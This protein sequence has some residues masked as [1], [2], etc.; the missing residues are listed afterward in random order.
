[1]I[2]SRVVWMSG[3]VERSITVSAPQRVAQVSLSTSSATDEVTDELPMLALTFTKKRRPM[4]IGSTLGMVDI[5]GQDGPP[6]ADLVAHDLR[7]DALPTA[8]KRISAVISP[9]RA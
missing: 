6:G 2:R 3:P 5:G 1:M 9:R 8:T 7:F 4:T